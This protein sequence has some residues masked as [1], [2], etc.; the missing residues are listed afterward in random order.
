MSNFKKPVTVTTPKG[1]A[2]FPWLNELDTKFNP[3]RDYK[4]NLIL[5]DSPVVR[6]KPA[7]RHVKARRSRPKSPCLMLRTRLFSTRLGAARPFV[8][9]SSRF[10]ITW[11]LPR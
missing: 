8:S 9:T 10:R 6:T 7:L 1:I 11:R 2:Q 4:T 3:D 5:E